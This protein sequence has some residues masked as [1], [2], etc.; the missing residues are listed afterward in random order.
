MAF[1]CTLTWV[2]LL[3]YKGKMVHTRRA[4]IREPTPSPSLE[5]TPS[6]KEE[7]SSPEQPP[8]SRCKQ[9]STSWEEE[10][11]EYDI[12]RFRHSRIKSGMALG[13]QKRLSLR[14]TWRPRWMTTTKCRRHLLD[15]DGKTFFNCH[16]TII[17][18]WWG[19]FTQMWRISTDTVVTRLFLGSVGN[20]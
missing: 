14:N 20:G 17:Q 10:L 13:W 15:L 8:R 2:N 12:T 5:E 19:N 9:A 7:S 16:D 6:S 1:F 4:V 3:A 11:A 18:I